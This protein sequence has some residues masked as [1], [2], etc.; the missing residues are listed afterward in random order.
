MT[1]ASVDFLRAVPDDELWR[2]LKSLASRERGATVELIAHLA[3]LESRRLHLAAGHGSLFAYCREVLLL[4]EHEAYNRIEAARAAQRFPVILDLLAQGA[5]NLTTVRLLAPHL[6][7]G[8][9]IEVLESARGLRRPQV[10]QVVARLAPKPDLPASLRKL[11][12]P[13]PPTT[14]TVAAD[15]SLTVPCSKDIK[16]CTAP[17]STY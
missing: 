7:P 1:N 13:T 15:A 6:T 17:V 3:E 12:A 2:R 10:E 5:V 9:H 8:N 14:T 16:A 11:P 4:S